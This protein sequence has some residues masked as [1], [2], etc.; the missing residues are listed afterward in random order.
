GFNAVVWYGVLAPKGTPPEVVAK[1][2]EAFNTAVKD[3]SLKEALDGDAI[4]VLGSTPEEF[5]AHIAS[6]L[7]VWAP[8][9]KEPGASLN[10]LVQP[11]APP[12]CGPVQQATST[13]TARPCLEQHSTSLSTLAMRARAN[14]TRHEKTS[15]PSV[16]HRLE[17]T[18]LHHGQGQGPLQ[19]YSRRPF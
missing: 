4:R 14:G 7:A 9:V 5:G 10:G 13:C 19:R 3:P 18:G 12:A 6:A 1:L 8:I 2:N 17:H 11:R 15:P 16:R